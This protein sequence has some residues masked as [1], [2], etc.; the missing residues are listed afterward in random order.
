MLIILGIVVDSI[1]MLFK[2]KSKLNNHGN[3]SKCIAM[4][5]K[6]MAK[7]VINN[8]EFLEPAVHD[9]MAGSNIALLDTIFSGLGNIWSFELVVS[10]IASVDFD[11][12]VIA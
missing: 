5:H 3:G 4:F 11:A 6:W 8:P 12:L 10:L 1:Q 2:F 9:F 7:D